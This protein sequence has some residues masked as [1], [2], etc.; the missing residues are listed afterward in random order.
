MF[1]ACSDTIQYVAE[2]PMFRI[3]TH[4]RTLD[5]FGLLPM[6]HS[7]EEPYPLILDSISE[8]VFIESDEGMVETPVPRRLCVASA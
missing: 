6:N 8:G 4:I 5:G 3:L 2:R 1:Q 7:P